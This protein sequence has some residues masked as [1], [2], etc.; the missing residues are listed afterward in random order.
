MK[1]SVFAAILAG[2]LSIAYP[3]RSFAQAIC[4]SDSPGI[5]GSDQTCTAGGCRDLVYCQVNEDC[6]YC[7]PGKTCVSD[8]CLNYRCKCN[9]DDDCGTAGLCDEDKRCVRKDDPPECG[10]SCLVNTECSP[11]GIGGTE[12][13]CTFDKDH[14]YVGLCCPTFIGE[15]EGN[16][17][18][19][20]GREFASNSNE[21]IFAALVGT[22]LM[23]RIRR[24]S[25]AKKGN[26]ANTH[27]P[28][29]RR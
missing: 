9:I 22:V 20:I 16:F 12:Y 15:P 3:H 5:C 13:N 11:S 8:A 27:T 10:R 24:R 14:P 28:S 4:Q 2:F 26:S 1:F 6:S 23:G 7:Q 29:P 25:A 19:D 17:S 21:L 18:C